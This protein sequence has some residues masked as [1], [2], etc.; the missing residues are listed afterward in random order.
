M[1]ENL[2]SL[3]IFSWIKKEVVDNILSNCKQKT[4]EKGEIIFIESEDS[5]WEWYII[6]SWS[7]NIVVWWK[8]VAELGRWNIVWEI[9]LLN[10]EKR[11]ATVSAVSDIEVIVLK[12]DDLINMINNDENKINKEIIKRIEENLEL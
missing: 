3:K 7:V 9:A 8:F 12:I 11:T 4:F 6:K 2:Y 10:E 5:N 1:S